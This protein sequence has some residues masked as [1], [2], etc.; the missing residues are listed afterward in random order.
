MEKLIMEFEDIKLK[1][2]N[3]TLNDTINL[4]NSSFYVGIK[5]VLNFYFSKLNEFPDFDCSRLLDE[6]VLN[7]YLEY[8]FTTHSINNEVDVSIKNKKVKK[9]PSHTECL[10]LIN[11]TVDLQSEEYLYCLI[12]YSCNVISL[13]KK[14]D[15][16]IIS[17]TELEFE[18]PEGLISFNCSE[19]ELSKLPKLPE[20]LREL[21]CSGN[22]FEKIDKLPKNLRYFNCSKNDEQNIDSDFILP[23]NLEFLIYDESGQISKFSPNLKVISCGSNEMEILPKLPKLLR[24]LNCS[25]NKLTFLPEFP[26]NLYLLYCYS[27]ELKEIS[28]IP[29]KLQILDCSCNKLE[30]VPNVPKKMKKFNCDENNF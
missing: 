8:M 24:I 6:N 23:D 12:L 2:M 26:P 3:L 1:K 18:L 13:P 29:S 19:N 28:N 5:K 9:I 16:L 14:L 15:K 25:R 10:E 21:D 4:V 20:S 17:D 7:C 27:N 11:C 22:C 30:K